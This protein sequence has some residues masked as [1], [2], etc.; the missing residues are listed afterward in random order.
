MSQP[1]CTAIINFSFAENPPMH[2]SGLSREKERKTECGKSKSSGN[3]QSRIDTPDRASSVFSAHVNVCLCMLC[4][5]V[6][7]SV[8]V[9]ACVAVECAMNDHFDSQGP[10]LK[11]ERNP[12]KSEVERK[13]ERRVYISHFAEHKLTSHPSRKWQPTTCV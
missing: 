9:R 8:H 4:T 13:R 1:N 11:R 2:P 10:K 7:V 12:G 3:D 5:C 6:R